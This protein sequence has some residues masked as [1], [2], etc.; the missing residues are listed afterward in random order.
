MGE[1]ELETSGILARTTTKIVLQPLLL[2]ISLESKALLC[3]QVVVESGFF[4]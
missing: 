3:E 2:L 1:L 4:A